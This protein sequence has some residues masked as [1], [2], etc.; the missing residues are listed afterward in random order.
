MLITSD[1]L[2]LVQ[3]LA[4]LSKEASNTNCMPTLQV[5]LKPDEQQEAKNA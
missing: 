3:R 5:D 2:E 1:W 4:A